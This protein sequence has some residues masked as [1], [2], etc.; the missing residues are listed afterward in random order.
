MTGEDLGRPTR[1]QLLIGAGAGAA[2]LTAGGAAFAADRLLAAADRKQA[3]TAITAR[4]RRVRSFHS[5]PDLRPPM[6]DVDGRSGEGGYLF[7]GTGNLRSTQGGPLIVGPHGEI[8]W[9][10][11]LRSPM[12]ETNFAATEYADRPVLTWWVG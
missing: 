9:F 4:A 5:R 1:R 10:R 6:I 8:L 11:P 7:L 3:N 12:W 2:A